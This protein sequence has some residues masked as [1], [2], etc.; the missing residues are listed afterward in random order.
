MQK[1]RNGLKGMFLA[2]LALLAINFVSAA[3]V[4]VQGV[5]NSWAN[6]GIFMYV[7]PFL[8]VF[9]LVF[10]I[11]SK[12]AILGENKAVHAIIAAALGLM[13]LVGDYFPKFLEK[14]SPNIAVAISVLLGVIILLGLFYDPEGKKGYKWVMGIFVGVGILAFLLV[15]SDTFSGNSGIGYNIWD[16][17][18]P[19]LITLLILAGIIIGIIKASK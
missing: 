8:L 11:L 13:S 1:E 6:A 7:L 2:G 14:F 15:I 5:L 9:A 19:A 4:T 16:N 12:T 3:P 18:G 10:G 17:Y